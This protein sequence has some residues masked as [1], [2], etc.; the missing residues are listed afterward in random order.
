VARCNADLVFRILGASRIDSI[1]NSDY[2]GANM[3]HDLNT[4]IPDSLVEQYDLVYDGGTLEHV[5]QFPTAFE[6]CLRMVKPGGQFMLEKPANG[7]CGHGIYQF[8]PELFFRAFAL[9]YGFEL[10][11]I[12]LCTDR[13][14][15]QVVDPVTVHGREEIRKGSG[16]LLVQ[17]RKIGDFARFSHSPRRRGRAGPSRPPWR[18]VDS[19]EPR[20]SRRLRHR[21][22]PGPRRLRIDPAGQRL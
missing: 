21:G 22:H 12:F 6:N 2:E 7:L 1:D 15:Y 16:S 14:E 17:A 18:S 13:G 4:S 3:I 10:V 8:S 9:Q 19:R 11:R 20:Q 5:Y